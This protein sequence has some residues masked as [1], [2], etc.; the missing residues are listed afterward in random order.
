MVRTFKQPPCPSRA[1]SFI[2]RQTGMSINSYCTPILR[3]RHN[4][5]QTSIHADQN[6]G[7]VPLDPLIYPHLPQK[8]TAH[9]FDM[10]VSTCFIIFCQLDICPLLIKTQILIARKPSTTQVVSPSHYPR[11]RQCLARHRQSKRTRHDMCQFSRGCCE[12][13]PNQKRNGS[14]FWSHH[15]KKRKR[16]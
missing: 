13:L 1:R 5:G 4:V 16:A 2:G 9:P 3:V 6:K 10:V 7:T 12:R 15:K 14:F 11:G 8:T